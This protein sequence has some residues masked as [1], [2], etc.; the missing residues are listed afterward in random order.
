M[1][2]LTIKEVLYLIGGVVAVWGFV[3]KIIKPFKSINESL[4]AIKQQNVD[5]QRDM[6]ELKGFVNNIKEDVSK[7]GDMIYQML[8]H[9]ATNN[10]TGNMKRCLDA[11]NE[12]NRHS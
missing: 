10:N 4:L 2:E 1:E 12:Y 5:K 6:D 11:Y 7:Q 8:D 9:M 3:E